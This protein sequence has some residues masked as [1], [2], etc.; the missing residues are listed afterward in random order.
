MSLKDTLIQLEKLVVS[1]ALEF[2]SIGKN[3]IP[4]LLKFYKTLSEEFAALEKITEIV[5]NLKQKL[6]YETIPDAFENV[7][8]D[9]VKLLGR[10]FIVGVRLNATIP[11]EMRDSG[12][13]W[14]REVKLDNLILPTVNPKALSSAVKSYIEE[15]GFEPPNDA[16]K[17]HK[18]KYTSIRKV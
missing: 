10:N 3:D 9:S 4:T 13:K 7:G 12:Y 14:L 5:G 16:V 1:G 11:L 8:Y 18:Q 6:S 15:T 2:D 17:I